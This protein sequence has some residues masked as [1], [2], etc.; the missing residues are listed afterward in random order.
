MRKFL[1]RA[2]ETLKKSSA[3]AAARMLRAFDK[4]GHDTHQTAHNAHDRRQRRR[5]FGDRRRRAIDRAW[6]LHDRILNAFRSV[7]KAPQ[8]TPVPDDL[9]HREPV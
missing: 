5:L 6:G 3:L 1:A 4:A 9:P 8:S 2:A 7:Q